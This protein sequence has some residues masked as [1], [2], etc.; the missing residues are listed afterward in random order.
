[1]KVFYPADEERLK[2][3]HH[4]QGHLQADRDQVVVENKKGQKA[5]SE[6]LIIQKRPQIPVP[7]RVKGPPNCISRST[8]H[9][10]K[11]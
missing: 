4:L 6:I 7:G 9:A 10:N 1:M 8:D 11:Q 3:S 5:E 2:K